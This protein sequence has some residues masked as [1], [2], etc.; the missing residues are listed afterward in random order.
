[1][2]TGSRTDK[3]TLLRLIVRAALSVAFSLGAGGASLGDISGTPRV[4]DGDTIV[5][6]EERVRLQGIDAPEQRQSCLEND[7]EWACGVAATA[8]LKNMIADRVVDCKG[9]ERDRYGRLIGVCFAAGQNLN[10][11]MVR[12]GWARAYRR[13][14]IDYLRAEGDAQR[15]LRGIWRGEFIRPWVWRT[16]N[17]R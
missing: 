11:D 17:R 1:M 5:I 3:L 9:S 7:L 2:D 16:K 10:E 13:Y 4:V 14:S 8:A 6:G 12:D 15:N